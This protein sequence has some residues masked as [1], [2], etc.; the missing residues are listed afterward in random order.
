M[1]QGRRESNPGHIGGR[2]LSALTTVPSLPHTPER[3]VSAVVCAVSKRL[4]NRVLL[5]SVLTLLSLIVATLSARSTLKAIHWLQHFV[6]DVTLFLSSTYPWY[7]S[8][9][10][11]YSVPR[12]ASPAISYTL[13]VSFNFTFVMSWN[14]CIRAR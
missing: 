8:A 9:T 6:L 13:R 12:D 3:C 11:W 4:E 5:G 2:R 7:V 14:L 1:T 10:S